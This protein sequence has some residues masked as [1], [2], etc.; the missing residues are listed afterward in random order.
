MP[1][2][3]V[4]AREPRDRPPGKLDA[5][6]SPLWP[7]GGIRRAPRPGS[8][9]YFLIQPNI[10]KVIHAING[11]KDRFI[12]LENEK[13]DIK[14]GRHTKY[15]LITPVRNEAAV[16]D[17]TIKSMIA[18]TRLPLKWVIVSDGSTDGTN[19]IVGE[20]VEKYEWIEF[21]ALPKCQK[22]S[23]AGKVH[24]FNMGY[25]KVKELDFQIVG[26][27]DGDISFD[28]EYFDFILRKFEENP[29]LG[30]AGTPF[31]EGDYQYDYRFTS[32]EHVSG[33]CQLFRR[34]CYESIGGYKAIA[35]GGI[36]LVAVVSARMNGWETRSFIEKSYIH[37][38]P[39][40]RASHGIVMT[41]FKGG[42]HDYLMGVH[43]VWQLFRSI[44]Q[45]RNKPYIFGGAILFA[46]YAWALLT[47]PQRPVSIE[48]IKFRRYE[49]IKRLRAIAIKIL[50]LPQ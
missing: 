28:N 25:E 18:Q 40:G 35:V 48:F 21:V 49:Q 13:I 27:I 37:H 15:V 36:D 20:Y 22:R 31:R 26:N 4:G 12:K 5:G 3:A 44:Y 11:I 45:M 7:A 34:E 19:E 30:V 1:V 8:P 16:I 46:G 10:R 17:G 32:D 47:S 29:R 50:Y 24:A 9:D 41:G 42:Y 6:T 2:D 39:I 23:F 33:A 43:P 38:R 14:E